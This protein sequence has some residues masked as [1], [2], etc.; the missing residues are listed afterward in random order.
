MLQHVR[1]HRIVGK[2]NIVPLRAYR[3]RKSNA[4]IFVFLLRE[5]HL[6]PFQARLTLSV[7]F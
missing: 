4:V 7:D 2:C 5:G 6:T 3:K 1:L